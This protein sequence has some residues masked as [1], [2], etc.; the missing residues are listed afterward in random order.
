MSNG[1]LISRDEF[2]KA[3]ALGMDLR[4][5]GNGGVKR[6]NFDTEDSKATSF[7]LLR[8][9]QAVG[10]FPNIAKPHNLVKPGPSV[11]QIAPTPPL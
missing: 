9:S 1:R 2:E 3:A 5:N 10:K 7:G 11:Q 4:Q 8:N 6:P